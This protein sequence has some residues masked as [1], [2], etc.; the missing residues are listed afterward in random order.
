MQK[1]FPNHVVWFMQPQRV[2]RQFKKDNKEKNLC[3]PFCFWG[4]R[5]SKSTNNQDS[6]L[7]LLNK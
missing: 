4:M 1:E 2:S 3:C 6:S 7:A 5:N